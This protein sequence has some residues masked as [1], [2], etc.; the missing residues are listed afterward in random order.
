MEEQ[1]S[2]QLKAVINQG[3]E[4]L[5][6]IWGE[7]GERRVAVHCTLYTVHC[8]LY[9]VHC[10]LYTVHCTLARLNIAGLG[11]QPVE[12]GNHHRCYYR[13]FYNFGPFRLFSILSFYWSLKNRPLQCKVHTK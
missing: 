2:G 6:G 11:K 7:I 10:I 5:Y 9:T 8:T 4:E 13:L 12:Q 1:R 3:L